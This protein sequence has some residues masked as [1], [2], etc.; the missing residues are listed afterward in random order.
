MG[1]FQPVLL[2]AAFLCSL[3]AGF[4]FAFAVVVMPGTAKLGDREFLRSFQ[5]ID[6][7]IQGNQPLFLLVWL[8]SAAALVLAAVLGAWRMEGVDRALLIMAVVAYLGGVQLPTVTINIPLNNAV[9]AIDLG[10]AD[11]ATVQQAR[12]AFESRWNRWNVARTWVACVV[13]L[14]LLILLLQGTTT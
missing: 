5:V 7:V 2:G 3:V 12:E 1:W 14:A 9:Q 4:L 13:S 10:S 11:D 6:G 8:G